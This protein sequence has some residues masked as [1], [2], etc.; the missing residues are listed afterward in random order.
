MLRSRSWKR[1]QCHK[2]PEA[3]TIATV[4][5]HAGVGVGTV[6]RVINGAPGV[7]EKTRRRVLE[8][9][10]ELDYQP[11]Q[12]A[13]S[14]SLGR[15]SHVAAVVPFL[16]HPSAVERLRGLVRELTAHRYE[17]TLHDVEL[18]E[19][20]DERLRALAVSGS[21]ADAAVIVSLPPT[22]EEVQR[23]ATARMPVVLLDAQHPDLPSIVIDNVAGGELATRHLL[24]LGNRRIA[25]IGDIPAN[26]YGFTSSVD[27]RAGWLRALAAAGITPHP[28]YVKEGDHDREVAGRLT[29]ELFRDAPEPPTAVFVAS[30]TQA[31]GVLAA[32]RARGL[33]IPDH[34]SVIGFDDIET[35]GLVGLTTV[36]QPLEESGRRAARLLLGALAGT[37]PHPMHQTLELSVS[38]RQTTAPPR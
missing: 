18:R 33:R 10:Q 11:N 19:Q 24:E 20:R 35:A 2:R 22:D 6:S 3:V 15:T 30:D 32:A 28:E 34:L 26:P 13:R 29:D 25:F 7:A 4:G 17:V 5:R 27:R 21:T 14:L 23:F 9:I 31:L 12:V 36:R 37:R 1:F 8:V 38:V 16:T